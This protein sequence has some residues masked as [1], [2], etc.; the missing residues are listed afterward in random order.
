MSSVLQASSEVQEAV[1]G[2]A[3]KKSQSL[4]LSLLLLTVN[5]GMSRN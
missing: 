4:D 2:A 5:E 3:S 1:L